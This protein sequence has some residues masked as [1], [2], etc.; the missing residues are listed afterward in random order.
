MLAAA[1]GRPYAIAYSGRCHL[2]LAQDV[3]SAFVAAARSSY[4]G[5]DVFN[6][7]GAVVEIDTVVDAIERALPGST[8]RI[9]VTGVPLPFPSEVDHG[10]FAEEIGAA[11]P[12]TPLFDGVRATITAFQELLERGLIDLDAMLTA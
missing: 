12:S 7:G 5:A 8:E 10:R 2:Q 4:T 11:E 9:T 3:A 1:A 6:L